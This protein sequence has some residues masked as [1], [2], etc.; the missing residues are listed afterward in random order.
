MMRRCE[1]D[2]TQAPPKWRGRRRRSVRRRAHDAVATLD[3]AGDAHL[4]CDDEAGEEKQGRRSR[5]E[6]GSVRPDQVARSDQ[7]GRGSFNN[8]QICKK[9]NWLP[10]YSS[11]PN[12][13]GSQRLRGSR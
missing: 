7:V 5:G 8:C 12:A 6:S 13:C 2:V 3:H 4:G 1:R 10:A 11:K 9:K